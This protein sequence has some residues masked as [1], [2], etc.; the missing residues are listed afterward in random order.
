MSEYPCI[1]GHTPGR[2]APQSFAKA[3]SDGNRSG[4]ATPTTNGNVRKAALP[5]T[6]KGTVFRPLLLARRFVQSVM[7]NP[8]LSNSA[9]S[10]H[11]L[12][13]KGESISEKNSPNR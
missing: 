4:Y 12:S 7:L 10:E 3:K 13:T 11:S 6:K 2:P 8:I 5:N 1:R 9:F